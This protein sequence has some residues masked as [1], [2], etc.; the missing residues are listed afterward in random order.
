VCRPTK[1]RRYKLS[2]RKT[3]SSLFFPE[4]QS[5]LSTLESF[6][7][8]TGRYAVPGY[9]HKLGLL[10]HGPPGTGKTSLIKALAAYTNRNIVSIPLARIKTNQDLMNIMFDLKFDVDG[11]DVPIE[12]A[13]KDTIFVMEDVDCAS[14]V[15]H[16]RRSSLSENP[17][18]DDE[19]SQEPEESGQNA[20]VAALVSNLTSG[21]KKNP[22]LDKLNLQGLLE[23]LDGVIDTE[24]RMVI[25]TTNHPEKLDPA[26]IRPGRIDK[27]IE[28]GYIKPA[29]VIELVEHYFGCCKSEK[30]IYSIFSNGEK[31]ITPAQIEQMAAECACE[32]DLVNK[33]AIK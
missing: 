2:N 18:E 5:L 23:C 21:D 6:S 17:A 15:V 32:V 31:R 14:K 8:K 16:Q 10:L 3:F 19:Y 9:P 1:C 26:L 27:I 22:T 33:I 13:F 12:L 4:K 20:V 24:D 29:Q 7:K 11:E 30:E 28:L 25:M